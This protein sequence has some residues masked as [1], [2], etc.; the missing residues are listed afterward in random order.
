MELT[1]R[2]KMY[3]SFWAQ[4]ADR[5][6][7]KG[8]H[9]FNV[10]PKARYY[11]GATVRITTVGIRSVDLNHV[12]LLDRARGHLFIHD[13]GDGGRDRNKAIFDRLWDA[14]QEIEADFRVELDWVT[15]ETRGRDNAYGV[16]YW[17]LESGGLEDK[18]KWYE[19]QGTMIDNMIRF[20]KALRPHLP[21]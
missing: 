1:P 8:G 17:I 2:K 12:I 6:R 21:N 18:D 3:L 7:V 16:Q 14:R 19:L 10:S 15:P 11:T 13:C 5:A 4:L 9:P 20:E